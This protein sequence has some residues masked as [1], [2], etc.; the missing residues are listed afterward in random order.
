MQS[1][2]LTLPRPSEQITHSNHVNVRNLNAQLTSNSHFNSVVLWLHANTTPQ[3]E[4]YQRQRLAGCS[5]GELLSVMRGHAAPRTHHQHMQIQ[6]GS[7]YLLLASEVLIINPFLHTSFQKAGSHFHYSQAGRGQDT[8]DFKLCSSVQWC[9][10]S[11]GFC[12]PDEQP[13]SSHQD[14]GS[15]IEC[16][17]GFTFWRI[18]RRGKVHLNPHSLTSS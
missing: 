13:A 10:F 15:V 5:G 3:R 2:L 18:R 16:K 9:G 7:R 14:A 6:P 11:R 12:Y 8:R 17:L 1:K 4:A